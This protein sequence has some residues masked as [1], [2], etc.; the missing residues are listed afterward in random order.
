MEGMFKD[1]ERSK[2]ITASFRGSKMAPRDLDMTF[3]VLSAAA[4]PTYA[5]IPMV[6]PKELQKPLA[7][8]EKFYVDAHK[9]RQLSWRHYNSHA[10][11]MAHFEKVWSC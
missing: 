2:E 11:L 3:D 6:L 4:W 1:I 9:G 5:D 7:A 10:H 8:F